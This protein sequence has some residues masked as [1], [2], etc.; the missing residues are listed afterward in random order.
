MCF[1]LASRESFP[2]HSRFSIAHSP[3]HHWKFHVATHFDM[4]NLTVV[5][6]QARRAIFQNFGTN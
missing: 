3:R 5:I 2:G 1:L 6:D 4:K